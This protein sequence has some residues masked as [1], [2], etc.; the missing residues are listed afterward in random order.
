MEDQSILEDLIRK[1]RSGD[2]KAEQELFKKLSVRFSV[3]IARELRKY[4]II[5]ER[6]NL[7][8][9][10]QEICQGAI[11]EV[12]MLCSVSNPAFSIVQTINVLH[13]V[14]DTFITNK[15]VELAKQ[16]SPEAEDL[17]FSILRK[18]LM[19]RITN[20]KWG[21]DKNGCEDR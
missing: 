14:L 5:I 3:L 10:R 11:Q 16:G 8:K 7:D 12:K 2:K 21:K 13:N 20:K 4:R 9:S 19:E 6:I 18:K 15:L 17:L 1:A